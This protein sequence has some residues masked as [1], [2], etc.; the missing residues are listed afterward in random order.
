MRSAGALVVAGVAMMLTKGVLLILTGTSPTSRVDASTS[1]SG[2]GICA[3]RS[4][5]RA[6]L[7]ATVSSQ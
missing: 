3:L 6:M 4:S 5:S 1:A 2:I 7:E